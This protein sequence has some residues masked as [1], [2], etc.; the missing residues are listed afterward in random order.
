MD[1]GNDL[2]NKIKQQ[3]IW[4]LRDAR[5]PGKRRPFASRGP[6]EVTLTREAMPFAP[7]P[8]A[9]T[10]LRWC[11]PSRSDSIRISRGFVRAPRR[12]GRHPRACCRGG[13]LPASRRRARSRRPAPPRG[14]REALPEGR[15]PGSAARGSGR[16]EGR[17]APNRGRGRPHERR[18]RRPG[19]EGRFDGLDPPFENLVEGGVQHRHQD[20][21]RA[22]PHVEAARARLVLVAVVD[23]AREVLRPRPCDPVVRENR[24]NRGPSSHL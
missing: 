5:S 4:C 12:A 6:Q 24:V 13:G 18:C 11:A 19:G 1:V 14:R 2:K 7:R 3:T 9:S 16:R 23:E 15:R 10:V 8:A 17:T 21:V 22:F 20:E